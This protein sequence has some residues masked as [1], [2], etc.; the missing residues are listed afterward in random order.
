MSGLGHRQLL[1]PVSAGC[2]SMS[3]EKT[4]GQS[5]GKRET[6]KSD[7]TKKIVQ[8]HIHAGSQEI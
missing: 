6:E 1:A 5:L 7:E 8:S 2:C 4:A 3:K